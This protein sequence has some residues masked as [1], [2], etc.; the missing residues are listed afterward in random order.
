MFV[1][2]KQ[3]Q[4]PRLLIISSGIVT[5]TTA[6]EILTLLISTLIVI[7]SLL[8]MILRLVDVTALTLR[9]VIKLKLT[10]QHL[11]LGL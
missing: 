11:N 10:A 9:Q 2:N 1:R 8:S 7:L 3:S 4:G 5:I 6:V